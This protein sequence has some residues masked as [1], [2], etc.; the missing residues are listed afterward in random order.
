M[1]E[2]QDPND[3]I[4]LPDDPDLV[5]AIIISESLQDVVTRLDGLATSHMQLVIDRLNSLAFVTQRRH[6]YSQTQLY[7]DLAEMIDR[8]ADAK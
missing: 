8:M 2:E 1:A 3:L 4:T 6:N 5:A 7:K